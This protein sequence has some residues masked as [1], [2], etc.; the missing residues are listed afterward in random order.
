MVHFLVV[1][2][3]AAIAQR[4]NII[5]GAFVKVGTIPEMVPT[6]LFLPATPDA[7]KTISGKGFLPELLPVIRFKVLIVLL[8]SCTHQS[9]L[10]Q[11]RC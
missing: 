5:N 9:L 6:Q 11:S 4:L 3:V 2:L 10:L 7:A 8:F 1:L